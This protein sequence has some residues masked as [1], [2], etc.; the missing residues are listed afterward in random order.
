MCILPIMVFIN[1]L[2]QPL[3][4]AGEGSILRTITRLDGH[5]KIWLRYGDFL[6]AKI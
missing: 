6:F 3:A 5:C 1:K 4:H 2:C